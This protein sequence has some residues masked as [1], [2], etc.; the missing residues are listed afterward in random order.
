MKI[1]F[2]IEEELTDGL[3][4]VLPDLKLEKTFE[5]EFTVI[6]HK[7]SDNILRVS[8]AGKEIS[9]FYKEKACFFRGLAKAVNWLK[10]GKEDCSIEEEP[11]FTTN[12]A[13]MDV[14][15]NAVMNVKTLKFMF[16]K[17]ALMGQNM[18]MLYT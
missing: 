3:E 18:F 14:S 12:G 8:K 15:R 5:G 10:N 7:V 11:I 4:H 1:R 16:R 13:M 2:L 6:A 17:M 9:I